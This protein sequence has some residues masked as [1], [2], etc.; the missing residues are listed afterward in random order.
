MTILYIL[1]ESY[2][3]SCIRD[4][5][6]IIPDELQNLIYWLFQ[7]FLISRL[8]TEILGYSDLLQKQ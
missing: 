2:L 6:R 4:L 1:I 5:E 8:Y 3:S 7:F